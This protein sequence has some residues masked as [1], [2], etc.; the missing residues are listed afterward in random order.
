MITEAVQIWFR[1]GSLETN[2][3]VEAPADPR[4][5]NAT[6]ASPATG[7]PI[8]AKART[9]RDKPVILAGP[10]R[11]GGLGAALPWLGAD[12]ANPRRHRCDRHVRVRERGNAG[13]GPEQG[14]EHELGGLHA[15]EPGRE[16]G[17][18]HPGDSHLE[19]TG[20]QLGA[21][22]TRSSIWVG[23]G[24]VV[25][26]D[27]NLEQIG[28]TAGCHNGK[29][30]HSAFYE[31]IPN[32]GVSV[33]KFPV[34]AGDT[35]TVTVSV[36]QTNAIRLRIQNRTR[37]KDSSVVVSVPGAAR[38]S[39]E[40][41]IEAPA[42]CRGNACGQA[43]LANFGSVTLS[44]VGVV[45]DGHTGTLIDPKWHATVVSLTPPRDQIAATGRSYGAAPQTM[46][47][48]GSG[49]TVAW[50]EHSTPAAPVQQQTTTTPRVYVDA[51][52]R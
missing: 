14:H 42:A 2:D 11:R 29:S 22:D 35:I 36:E 33:D 28:T 50:R 16:A 26:L 32:P 4:Q 10:H 21:L 17:V 44:N 40:W 51:P 48:N 45:G 8:S 34:Q 41:I 46:V 18:V 1:S 15:H 5:A 19:G 25:P 23:I 43:D 39:A 31:V 30:Q 37:H 52:R 13:A 24:G 7:T 47:S 9:F 27:G 6:R 20:S 38:H 3:P 12:R 49:F